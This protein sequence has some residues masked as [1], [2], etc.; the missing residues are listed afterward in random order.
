MTARQ[1]STLS[2]NPGHIPVLM[3]EVITSLAL[4]EGDVIVDGTFGA[5]GYS[6]AIL[7]SA[8][9]T[10]IGIDR[11]PAAIKR[12]AAFKGH[13]GERFS[14]LE[15]CFGD[16]K[17][18]LAAAGIDQVDGIVLDIGV[19]SFQLDEA[20]RGF[21]FMKDGPLDMR[22]SL[23]GESAADVVNTYGEE[24][25]A[26]I[27]YELGEER[28]SRR[29][30]SAIVR[31]RADGDFTKTSELADVVAKAIGFKRKKN[32]KSI[33]PATKTFQALR[34]HVNDELGELKKAL[35]AS[36]AVLKPGGRLVVVSFH[37][38]ED[39]IVKNF[40]IEQAGQKP[41]GNRHLPH[42]V[43]D[44]QSPTFTIKRKGATKPSDEEIERNPRSRSSRLR[45]AIRTDVKAQEGEL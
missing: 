19:S 45:V 27:I 29:I 10:L 7:D 23:S 3:D 30:A 28:K 34:I 11:D 32:G 37:S 18:L 22:M 8:D 4:S 44:T 6:Q 1:A 38:L 39:R 42:A 25:I 35:K 36:L 31:A 40:M 41:S 17:D 21:S 13:Y 33:H 9:V 16:M 20:D 14:I 26:N 43:T 24:E 12:A 15:G 2:P 5:G